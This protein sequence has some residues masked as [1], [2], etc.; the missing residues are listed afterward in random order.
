[1]SRL[2]KPIQVRIGERI[3]AL[4]LDPRPAGVKKLTGGHDRYRFKVGEYR[5][6]YEIGDQVL[7]VLVVRVAHRRD[8]YRR[9]P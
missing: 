2:P 8:A 4:A 5:V 1:L 3:D 6:I 9:L 7:H